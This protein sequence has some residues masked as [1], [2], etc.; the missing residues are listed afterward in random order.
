MLTLKNIYQASVR[1][2]NIT[3][4]TPLIYCHKLSKKYNANVLIKVES[5]QISGSF[6]YRGAY[7]KIIQIAEKKQKKSIV[8]WSS[9][10][11]AYAV[12]MAAKD[13]NVKAHIIMPEDAPKIKVIN[14]KMH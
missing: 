6:K 8:A 10:N 2:K 1:L 14:T 7:N 13:L 3:S 5:L 4:I 12:A 11:H 9:G